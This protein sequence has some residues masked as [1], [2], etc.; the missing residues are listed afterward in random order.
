MGV[1]IPYAGDVYI[2][3]EGNPDDESQRSCNNYIGVLQYT[4]E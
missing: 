1:R 3:Q 4:Y 2:V